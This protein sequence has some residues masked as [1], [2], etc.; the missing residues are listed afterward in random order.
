MGIDD[1]IK[2]E[3]ENEAK[4]ID[5]LLIDKQGIVGLGMDAFRGGLRQWMIL[6]TVV[7]FL[8]SAAMLWSA[9]RFYLAENIDERIFW[10]VWFI[11]SLTAQAALKQW[12]WMEARR[13]AT[14]RE[15]KRVEI[16]VERLTS[17]IQN[18]KV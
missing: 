17:A 2:K 1:R 11:I 15:I 6:A 12:A 4:D 10:G 5:E 13:I 14:L 3:L 16:A 18:A 7:I 9:Y 8:V